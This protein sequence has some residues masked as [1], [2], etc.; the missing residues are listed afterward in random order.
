M[1]WRRVKDI[2]L[3]NAQK[4]P[5]SAR[6]GRARLRAKTFFSG[7]LA[8]G[9]FGAAFG[10]S[11][12][13]INTNKSTN[14]SARDGGEMVQKKKAKAG[15]EAQI[16]SIIK[17][18]KAQ[19]GSMGLDNPENREMLDEL[20]KCLRIFNKNPHSRYLEVK[21]TKRLEQELEEEYGKNRYMEVANALR[22]M[23]KADAELGSIPKEY[24]M[25]GVL[26]DVLIKYEKLEGATPVFGR[27]DM[28]KDD[29]Y[30]FLR[31]VLAQGVP[32]EVY[33][34]EHMEPGLREVTPVREEGLAKPAEPVSEELQSEM[35]KQMKYLFE[36]VIN[37]EV[38]AR[39]PQ[40]LDKFLSS[41]HSI[42]DGEVQDEFQ[43][44]VMNELD[45]LF[46]DGE[47]SKGP[48]SKIRRMNSKLI[49]EAEE[50]AKG[51][52]TEEGNRIIAEASRGISNE[53]RREII[54]SAAR[55]TSLSE[56]NK[57]FKDHNINFNI[58]I[59][60][61]S[62]EHI[63]EMLVVLGEFVG[64]DGFDVEKMEKSISEVTNAFNSYMELSSSV[65]PSVWNSRLQGVF[66]EVV[67]AESQE[68]IDKLRSKY[69][70]GM[71][72]GAFTIAEK[73]WRN[74]GVAQHM[75]ES[76]FAY[77]W[78]AMAEMD[79]SPVGSRKH[80]YLVPPG[81]RE[82][83]L[84]EERS[85]VKLAKLH[86]YV[87]GN[88]KF[89]DAKLHFIGAMEGGKD[90]KELDD[91]LEGTGEEEASTE[92]LAYA[93]RSFLSKMDLVTQYAF[94]TN[95]WP[96]MESTTLELQLTDPAAPVDGTV[97]IADL[98]NN[99]ALKAEA[100][101][102]VMDVMETQLLYMGR[103]GHLGFM[104]NAVPMAMEYSSSYNDV[105]TI[106]NT[107][108]STTNQ[109]SNTQRYA[110]IG[111]G[112]VLSYYTM[113]QIP[114]AFAEAM[115]DNLRVLEDL[116]LLR[117]Q[118]SG[119]MGTY[120]NKDMFAV[121]SMGEILRRFMHTYAR[122][123][124]AIR[125]GEIPVYRAPQDSSITDAMERRAYELARLAR[126]AFSP[127]SDISPEYEAEAQQ[128]MEQLMTSTSEEFAQVW[129]REPS[130]HEYFFDFFTPK[131]AKMIPRRTYS[132]NS[133]IPGSL[134][135][136]M[137]LLSEVRGVPRYVPGMEI[138]RGAVSAYGKGYGGEVKDETGKETE[139]EYRGMERGYVFGPETQAGVVHTI[140]RGEER[141]RAEAHGE[142]EEFVPPYETMSESERNTLYGLFNDITAPGWFSVSG[143]AAGTWAETTTEETVPEHTVE[144][145]GPPAPTQMQVPEEG[146][147]TK[148]TDKALITRL[149]H[150]A[151]TYNTDGVTLITWEEHENYLR[152]TSGG[153][154]ETTGEEETRKEF[155]G[156][157]WG[158]IKGDWYRIGYI[159]IEPEEL[160]RLFTGLQIGPGE[161]Y[162]AFR[163]LSG[164]QKY[165]MG[166]VEGVQ[167][168]E[169]EEL[170]GE[171]VP[172]EQDWGVY[173]CL[174]GVNFTNVFSGGSPPPAAPSVVGAGIYNAGG[175]PA[176]RGRGGVLPQLPTLETE[177]DA[178]RI[179]QEYAGG[180]SA[181][182]EK[183]FSGMRNAVGF[184]TLV[185]R[186][187]EAEEVGEKRETYLAGGEMGRVGKIKLG[188][189]G[190]EEAFAAEESWIDGV[191][192]YTF[193]WQGANVPKLPGNNELYT[194]AM[195]NIREDE[196]NA[197]L[198]G[199]MF[200]DP[201][202]LD[203]FLVADWRHLS[204]EAK[205]RSGQYG[206]AGAL[207]AAEWDNGRAQASS[208][209][210]IMRT[211]W[212]L[213]RVVAELRTV[214]AD[215]QELRD[216][217]ASEDLAYT[218]RLD[219]EQ[220]KGDRMRELER[221]QNLLRTMQTALGL[222][223]AQ[224]Y[225][226]TA[227]LE[228]D[229]LDETTQA[230]IEAIWGGPDE[231]SALINSYVEVD[232]AFM[233]SFNIQPAPWGSAGGKVIVP[234][235]HVILALAA[236]E[237]WREDL[238]SY[239][240][241]PSFDAGVTMLPENDW[242]IGAIVGGMWRTGTLSDYTAEYGPGMEV[243]YGEGGEE[244]VDVSRNVYEAMVLGWMPWWE[245]SRA[246]GYVVLSKEQGTN[247]YQ[248]KED[249]DINRYGAGTR[250]M[251]V[252]KSGVAF[253]VDLEYMRR[254]LEAIQRGA[255][256][257]HY[258]ETKDQ[259]GAEVKTSDSTDT[260]YVGGRGVIG[261]IE[262]V[263]RDRTGE[264]DPSK[265]KELEG[266]FFLFGGYK[267]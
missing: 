153:E 77:N 237:Y 147:Y 93:P 135:R 82:E 120:M 227:G 119:Y 250:L 101:Q 181:M 214:E 92:R 61:G 44:Y 22:E 87:L 16:D 5:A 261:S 221:K 251:W 187:V 11:A 238:R 208:L 36:A 95:T 172:G 217:R 38:I 232:D 213:R 195:A 262:R 118:A 3:V 90:L 106:L 74:E 127:L 83:F 241:I 206:H 28:L 247:N 103:A 133:F 163:M 33:E 45:K 70:K 233:L 212:S 84:A 200:R 9:I 34:Q 220:S 236:G 123:S 184:V 189:R 64:P 72:A 267:W 136:L 157:T 260:W 97:E 68:E 174:V 40:A 144:M 243:E 230:G 116:M 66:L 166:S 62:A 142:G 235:T 138:E 156:Y 229:M 192:E 234:T 186:E 94:C 2:Q 19:L 102:K 128:I 112:R 158:R 255:A 137:E 20:G 176:M 182:Y 188:G 242:G 253:T 204:D 240:G 218:G 178:G 26:G 125:P 252:G 205:E 173:G 37:F 130:L 245:G 183:G 10:A 76:V 170:Q 154:T 67:S 244:E 199:T 79:L 108:N 160:N 1:K 126:S 39:D 249:L 139:K 226:G 98:E 43:R 111:S 6:L 143:Y 110:D 168:E 224:R 51:V 246:Q 161:K 162:G 99:P 52:S 69:S 17:N 223:E 80:H 215:L 225:F 56:L 12:Q 91:L 151:R 124:G 248:I 198:L 131:K 31:A 50:E 13:D 114:L 122:R 254:E 4:P 86:S 7:V 203:A 60:F 179:A 42:R 257:P 63:S 132:V 202:V 231:W 100:N 185:G 256:R 25:A 75:I 15:I 141:S 104:L 152:E 222:I 148:V 107:V 53:E 193:A 197:G 211:R 48:F 78:G 23:I 49:A 169:G 216:A 155:R 149:E 264:L 115:N 164:E 266:G 159:D 146:T 88:K 55:E 207:T 18:A 21:I 14:Y 58:P 46:G 30:G 190:A 117:P 259:F 59:E 81:E 27:R 265:V 121:R 263:F 41:Y 96:A 73:L 109:I 65:D 54:L 32:A 165:Q 209:W 175:R 171:R 150:Y 134:S 89:T 24:G 105:V 8:A 145:E 194:L 167:T 47:I 129:S 196:S 228:W 239:K 180:I 201:D 29:E 57:F 191:R 71:E 219:R 35:Q 177:T 113:V 140:D 85:I 258:E 210:Q